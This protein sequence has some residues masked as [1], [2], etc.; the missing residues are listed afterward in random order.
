MELTMA[1]ED[2]MRRLILKATH[3]NVEI[4]EALASFGISWLEVNHGEHP[5]AVAGSALVRLGWWRR[6]TSSLHATS[7]LYA[8]VPKEL[9]MKMLILGYLPRGQS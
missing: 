9:A 2:L 8:I 3:P 4:T 1:N 6:G 7:S 5:F